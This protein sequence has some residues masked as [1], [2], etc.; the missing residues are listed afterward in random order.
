MKKKMQ[1]KNVSNNEERGIAFKL[2]VKILQVRP[3]Y[4]REASGGEHGL[5]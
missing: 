1:Y 4:W 2:I 5:A 3:E